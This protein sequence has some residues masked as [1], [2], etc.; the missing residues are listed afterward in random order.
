[1]IEEAQDKI[2]KLNDRATS[3][4]DMFDDLKTKV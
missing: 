3:I 2:E 4:E 1:M